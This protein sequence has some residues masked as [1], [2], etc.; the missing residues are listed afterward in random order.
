M[1]FFSIFYTSNHISIPTIKMLNA[2]YFSI[3]L[4]WAVIDNNSLQLDGKQKK[5][6]Y[7]SHQLSFFSLLSSLSSL[8]SLFSL[9]SPVP[10]FVLG[11]LAIVVWWLWY[12]NCGPSR[13]VGPTVRWLWFWFLVH[14][15]MFL[16]VLINFFFLLLFMV[17]GGS[18]WWL[19]AAMV[20]GCGGCV[21]C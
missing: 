4:Q 5:N 9:L 10:L 7:Y 6:I 11:G 16:M 8:T 15:V 3:Q 21:M 2:K 13:V 1:L 17:A 19:V 20:G 18:Y 14:S 12:T